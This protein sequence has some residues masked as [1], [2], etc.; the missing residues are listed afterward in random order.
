M[1]QV[2]YPVYLL[3][4]SRPTIDN[5]VSCY[6]YEN[7]VEDTDGSI[8]Q[9]NKVLFIDDTTLPGSTLASRRLQLGAL[10]VPLLKLNRAFFFI[11]DIL[12]VAEKGRWFIDTNGKI[13]T[14]Q[15]TLRVPLKFHRVSKLFNIPTGGAVIECKNIATRFKT[16]FYPTIPIEQLHAGILEH[17]KGLILYGLYDKKH[18]DT[19]RMI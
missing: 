19:W 15:K 8:I 11:G 1:N 9:N 16:L 10:G 12:K 3:R 18:K 14:I 17:S 2:S 6:L 5:G 4:K 7:L 13:F